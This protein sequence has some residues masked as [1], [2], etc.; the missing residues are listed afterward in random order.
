MIFASVTFVSELL[1]V[2]AALL[3]K[4]VLNYHLHNFINA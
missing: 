3:T 4:E 2:S 1:V